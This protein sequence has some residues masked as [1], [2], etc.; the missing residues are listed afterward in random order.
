MG[1]EIMRIT[2]KDRVV[3]HNLELLK[4][5]L[6]RSKEKKAKAWIESTTGEIRTKLPEG[7]VQKKSAWKAV[8]IHIETS[9]SAETFLCID[10]DSPKGD[11]AFSFEGWTH[12]AEHAVLETVK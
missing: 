9:P 5:L 2:V 3:K 10:E 4:D 6:I 8:Q 7:V 1:E 11:R 12:R